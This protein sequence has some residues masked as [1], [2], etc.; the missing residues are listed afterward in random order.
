GGHAEDEW[1][2]DLDPGYMVM[3]VSEQELHHGQPHSRAMEVAV[4]AADNGPGGDVDAPPKELLEA[5]EEEDTAAVVSGGCAPSHESSDYGG[6][7][8]GGGGVGADVGS[9][10]SRRRSWAGRSMDG[11]GWE[12]EEDRPRQTRASS[13]EGRASR[14]RLLAVGSSFLG[15]GE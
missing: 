3:A 10:E 9:G 7:G 12:E 4:H 6:G 13:D 11:F 8:G 1:V 15:Q 5:G 2:D 14:D